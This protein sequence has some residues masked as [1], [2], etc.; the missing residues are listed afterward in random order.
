MKF[1]SS[2]KVF[3]KIHKKAVQKSNFVVDHVGASDKV[4]W[5]CFRRAEN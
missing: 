1:K 4:G 2:M 5:I 3:V